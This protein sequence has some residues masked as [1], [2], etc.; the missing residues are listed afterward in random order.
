MD[1]PTLADLK[2]KVERALGLEDEEFVIPEELTDYANDAIDEAEAEIHSNNPNYFLS[3]ATLTLVSGQEEYD[4]PANIYAFKIRA[5]V[6]R[7]GTD[8]YEIKKCR[9]W[10]QFLKYA[11]DQD[12][13]SSTRNYRYFIINPSADGQKILL[14]PTPNESGAYVTVWYIRNANTLVDDDDVC[15]IPEFS[16]FIIEYM[17]MRCYEKEGH[18]NFAACNARVEAKRQQMI[19]TLTN[20]IEDPDNEIEPDFRSYDEQI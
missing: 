10:N 16:S 5:I 17:K 7:N 19:D 8:T 3:R 11:L 4:L 15:D 6:Y 12:S 14:T 18:P 2:L 9:E 13:D 1:L 20:M